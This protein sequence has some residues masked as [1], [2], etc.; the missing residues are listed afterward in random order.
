VIKMIP[1]TEYRDI[2]ILHYKKRKM[3]CVTKTACGIQLI[4]EY[5]DDRKLLIIRKHEKD[6]YSTSDKSKVT[7]KNCLRTKYF[8]YGLGD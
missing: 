5:D 2:V 8:D 3:F 4:N 6:I 7:C 1:K